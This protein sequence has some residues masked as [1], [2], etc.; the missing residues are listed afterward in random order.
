MQASGGRARGHAETDG[1]PS[2]RPAVAA[3][4]DNKAPLTDDPERDRELG[5]ILEALRGG[6]LPPDELGERVG[7][8]TWPHDRFAAAL[9]YG[10]AVGALVDDGPDDAVRARF[11]D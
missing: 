1:G 8:G 11:Q 7:A 3:R 4:R 5:A 2:R 9:H 10:L 6:P